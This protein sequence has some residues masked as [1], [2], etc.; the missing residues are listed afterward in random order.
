MLHGETLSMTVKVAGPPDDDGEPTWT[1]TTQT[2][3]GCNVQPVMEMGDALF[4]Q[5]TVTPH[6]KV[7]GPLGVFLSTM[8]TGDSVITWR[9]L[10]FKVDGAVQ[11]YHTDDGLLDHSEFYLIGAD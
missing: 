7:N 8:I 4:T 2:I 1:T 3:D 11:D 6:Y 5:T 10:K 9:G